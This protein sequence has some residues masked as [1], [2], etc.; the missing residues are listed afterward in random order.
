MKEHFNEKYMESEKY[1]H[2]TFTG[3]IENFDANSESQKVNATG[4]LTIHGVTKN[5]SLPATMQKSGN[6]YNVTSKFLV[7][8]EDY[9]ITIP[10]LLF[11]NIAESVEVT[12]EF[13]F[14]PQ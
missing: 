2:A 4:K 8:L 10:Q 7:K 3:S 6:T 9:H 14:E 5:V 1:P 12:V 13:S 11:Q